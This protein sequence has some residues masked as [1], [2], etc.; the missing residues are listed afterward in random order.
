M[1]HELRLCELKAGGWIER[2]LKTQASG[3]TGNMGR[4]GKPFVTKYWEGEKDIVVGEDENFLGGLNCTDDAWTPF[5]Q[6]AYW[7]DGMIRCGWLIDDKKLIEY[8]EGKIYP[9]IENADADGYIG[10]SFLK[11]GMLWAHSV[12]F[13]ALIA[14]YE[15][16][17]DGRILEALK[18]HYIRADLK[19]RIKS[20]SGARIIAVRD[21]SIADKIFIPLSFRCFLCIAISNLLRENLSNL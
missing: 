7:I 2:F 20:P 17:G 6:N 16:T 15:A 4:I 21:I 3:L 12:Y 18:K 5:E 19:E 1:I 9:A 10:P 8:A 14:E 13:R 11:D